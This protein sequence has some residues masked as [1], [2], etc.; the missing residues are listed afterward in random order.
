MCRASVYVRRHTCDFVASRRI[1]IN[2]CLVGI[3]DLT[4]FSFMF[5]E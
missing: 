4:M 1:V 2:A 5:F 3:A